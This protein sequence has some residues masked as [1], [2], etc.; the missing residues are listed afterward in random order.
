MTFKPLQW[1][2]SAHFQE[3]MLNLG[4]NIFKIKY[5]YKEDQHEKLGKAISNAQNRAEVIT[6]YQAAADEATTY[7]KAVTAFRN[8]DACLLEDEEYFEYILNYFT[9]KEVDLLHF[10][11]EDEERF[12]Q[13]LL[14]KEYSKKENYL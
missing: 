13:W 2:D 9:Q 14:H 11:L 5:F 4:Y 6:G 1:E 3:N 12:L 8:G 10:E 7:L